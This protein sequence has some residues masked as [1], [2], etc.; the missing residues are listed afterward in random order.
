MYSIPSHPQSSS[1]ISSIPTGFVPSY[2]TLSHLIPSHPI[3]LYSLLFQFLS[4]FTLFLYSYVFKCSFIV[5]FNFHQL[6]SL[7][8]SFSCWNFPQQPIIYFLIWPFLFLIFTLLTSPFLL[9][10]LFSFD[11][12][13]S[14]TLI[15]HDF[16][17]CILG[18]W[19]RDV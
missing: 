9:P 1:P 14:S 15:F 5:Y 19:W 8:L 4:Y 2:P 6:S 11:V 12:S 3:T 13:L 10:Y 7:S 16:V 18:N 17:I